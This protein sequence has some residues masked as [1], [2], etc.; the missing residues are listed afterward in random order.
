DMM[1][2]MAIPSSDLLNE[3]TLYA[4]KVV[5]EKETLIVQRSSGKNIVVM[6]MEQFNE[7]QKEIFLAKNAQEKK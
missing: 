7:M 5:D 2:M 4:D 1:Y 6:S 3:F